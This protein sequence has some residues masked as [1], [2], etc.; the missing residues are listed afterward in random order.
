[1][2]FLRQGNL[3]KARKTFGLALGRA[4]RP[5]IFAA[6]TN[7]ELQLV[8][9]DRC[10]KI[11]EK[12]LETFP[13]SAKAWTSYAQFEAALD[14][15][16]RA[17]AIYQLAVQQENMEMP[18]LV[19]K[20]FIEFEISQGENLRVKQLYEELLQSSDHVKVWISYGSWLYGVNKKERDAARAVF[21]RGYKSLKDQTLNEERVM[22]LEAWLKVDKRN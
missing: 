16:E 11:Q 14:E 3:D 7:L 13:N 17:R 19:W 4:P 6:Y 2:Y 18:E 1:M 5:S 8:E 10:R 21:K 15:T 22:L 9:I 20:A 12:F